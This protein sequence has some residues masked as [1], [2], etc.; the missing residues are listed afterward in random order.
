MV[1]FATGLG[2]LGSGGNGPLPKIYQVRAPIGAEVGAFPALSRWT[3]HSA[4]PPFWA[5]DALYDPVHR[6]GLFY[7]S[8]GNELRHYLLI[9][10]A[11]TPPVT[12]KES[13]L[14][15]IAMGGKVHL[16]D[17][18]AKV[19]SALDLPA[20]FFLTPATKCGFPQAALYSAARLYGPPHHPPA[21]DNSPCKYEGPDLVPHQVIGTVVFRE[22]RVALLVWEYCGSWG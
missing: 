16:G 20:S 21:K 8:N 14:S 19:R 11:G 15:G 12:V 17:S 4:V 7:E 22:N 13:H 1:S 18:L 5:I 9:A 2:V 10:N 6:I 3:N